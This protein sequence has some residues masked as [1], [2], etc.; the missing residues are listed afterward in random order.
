MKIAFETENKKLLAHLNE[1]AEKVTPGAQVSALNSVAGKVRGEA[2][3]VAARATGVSTKILRKRI[4]VP[5][6]KKAT[7]RSP[8][9]I[10]FGGI[11]PVKV[12]KLTPKPRNLAS[13]RVKYKTPPGKS[14]DP[15]AFIAT[16]KG[17]GVAVFARKGASRL[18]LKNITIDI[19][20]AVRSAIGVYSRSAEAKRHYEK[21]LFSQMDRRV[22]SSLR[23]KGLDVS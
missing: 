2:V 14:Q 6:S 15:N 21:I 1:F 17:G 13:G 16:H 3:K 20:P 9:V 8:N 10:V 5:R 22:R 11:W 18:P 23:R 4:V 12:S 19:G 7:L